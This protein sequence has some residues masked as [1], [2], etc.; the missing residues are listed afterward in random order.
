MHAPSTSDACEMHVQSVEKPIASLAL[1]FCWHIHYGENIEPNENL[2]KAGVPVVLRVWPKAVHWF[3]STLPSG[4][5]AMDYLI[6]GPVSLQ[7]KETFESLLWRRCSGV[8]I[9]PNSK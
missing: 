5:E 6:P 1:R 3:L 9:T 8:I 4:K 7:L 2:K